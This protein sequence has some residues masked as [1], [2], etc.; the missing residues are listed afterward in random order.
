MASIQLSAQPGNGMFLI[1]VFTEENNLI[2]FT[3]SDNH[4][5]KVYYAGSRNT[6]AY[7]D[8]SSSRKKYGYTGFAGG[9]IKKIVIRYNHQKM[10][11]RLKKD[12][13][14]GFNGTI[15]E[16]DPIYFK[17]GKY[18]LDCSKSSSQSVFTDEDIVPYYWWKIKKDE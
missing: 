14:S 17:Q 7:S 6:K 3:P 8:T 16:I 1:K 18:L 5:V 12:C 9:N 10:T 11:I 4:K 2:L 15:V 13:P